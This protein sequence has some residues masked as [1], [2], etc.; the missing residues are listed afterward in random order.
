MNE[1]LAILYL[2]TAAVAIL[3]L[4][5]VLVHHSPAVARRVGW[6]FVLTAAAVF[7]EWAIARFT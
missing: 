2:A 3:A 6:I 4:F 5:V 7:I 1:T